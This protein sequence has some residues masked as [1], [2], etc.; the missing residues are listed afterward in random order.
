[1]WISG[2]FKIT[3]ECVLFEQFYRGRRKK[4]EF[5]LFH[6]YLNMDLL[7]LCHLCL[8][9]KGIYG[10]INILFSALNLLEKW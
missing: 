6:E 9:N 10:Q 7:T 3:C 2:F 4:S 1:M 5:F 8:K